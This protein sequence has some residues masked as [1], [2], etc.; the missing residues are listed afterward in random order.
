M[1][2]PGDSIGPYQVSARIGRG[3]MGEVFKAHDPRLGRDVALKVSY[4]AFSDRF[5]R[6]ARSIAALNHTNICHLYDVG[7]DYLVLEFV[8]GES[9][10]G[11]MSFDEALPIISQ[12]IDGIEAAHERNIIHRDLKPANIKITPEGIVKILDFGLAKALAQEG[13]GATTDP[14]NSPTVAPGLS[15]TAQ[16]TILGTAAYMAPEQARGR[17]ADRRADIWAFGVIVYELLTG[18]QLFE[19]ETPAEILGGVLHKAP[20]LSLVPPR[21]RTLVAWCL[22]PDRTNR[23]QAIGD[24]RRLLRDAIAE[25]AQVPPRLVRARTWLSGAGWVVAAIALVGLAAAMW[26][27]VRTPRVAQSFMHLSMPLP[28]D[29]PP[30]FLALSPDGR[31]LVM[32]QAGAGLVVRSVDSNVVRPLAGTQLAR[33]PFWSPDSSTI[34]F[35]ADGALKIVPASGGPTQ[36]LCADNGYGM[37]GTWSPDGVILYATDSGV[38]KRVPAG[39]GA[40]TDVMK[41]DSETRRTGFPM[42][43]PDG[44]H[45]LYW[46]T[47][48]AAESS[49]VFVGTLDDPAGHRLLADSSSVEFVPDSP[50]SSVGH[51]LFVREGNLVAQSFDAG[52]L[53]VAGQPFVV[54][55]QV[56]FTSTRPQ[57]AASA[58]A[59]G[60]IAVL[61]N[62]YPERELRWYDRSGKDAG[63]VA[64]TG[65]LGGGVS[66]AP[67]GRSVGFVRGSS[68]LAPESR[69]LDLER[70]QE[71]RL[72]ATASSVVWSPDS[73]RIAFGSEVDGTPGLY[74]RGA[75]GGLPELLMPAGDNPLRPSDWSRDGQYIIYTEADPKTRG[76]LWLLP[77]SA[78]RA[79]IP[80]VR[81]PENESQG[82]LSPDGSWLA[83]FSTESSAPGVFLRRL[84]EDLHV[85]DAVLTASAANALEPRW[86]ADGKEL[87]YLE[88]ITGSRRFKLIAVP[89][90]ERSDNP[91]GPPQALFEFK[92]LSQIQEFNAF[93]Y[94]PSPD[95]Q[96]FLVNTYATDSQSTLDLLINW[97]ASLAR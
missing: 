66:L 49:G 93:V 19:G 22:E 39:G 74:I 25:S 7:P 54:A 81:T 26:L 40:C 37:G 6:E 28:G 5:T 34:A 23:L 75:A 35:F 3:G 85:S 70:N 9:L 47:T 24:A 4:E 36:I 20:D 94:S 76:D 59:V 65:S 89:I 82:A 55:G 50:G 64:V 69:L 10:H 83:Y 57:I 52:A 8:E 11:P 30:S 41:P 53:Q 31:L 95:G 42:F 84:S 45:F 27:G 15:A 32:R 62:G 78:P 79:P 51:L 77:L 61:V 63:R 68:E 2:A 97:P 60:T 56:D 58:S 13:A 1:I 90:N 43:L 21:A 86:R 38:F 33:T 92:V 73:R 12:L 17:A 96:R 44:A 18:K 80:L 71:S 72:L 29:A 67:D 91:L 16:G 87:F 48:N 88:R 46:K 14:M